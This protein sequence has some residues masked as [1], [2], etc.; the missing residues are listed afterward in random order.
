MR[1]GKIVFTIGLILLGI[2]LSDCQYRRDCGG[3][4]KKKIKTNMGGYM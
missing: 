1:R 3:R 2:I 4:R